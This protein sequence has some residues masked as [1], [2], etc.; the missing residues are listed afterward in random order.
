MPKKEGANASQ[1]LEMKNRKTAN[2][3]IYTPLKLAIEMIKMCDI[4]ENDN[5][6]DC[7]LGKGIFYNNF[8]NCNSDWCE[9]EKG[10]DFFEYTKDKKYDWIIGNPPYSLWNK[11]LDH[12][13]NITDKFCYIFGVFN[14]TPPRVDTILKK[15]FGIT[16][17]TICKVHWWFS[18]SFL[19]VFEKDKK[20]VIDV[21]R[22]SFLC[23]IC[24]NKRCKRG[25]TYKNKKYGIN[26]CSKN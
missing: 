26:E 7:S 25:R 11:W 2:D 17:L 13:C 4:K 10:R 16:R 20:S 8:P 12:T 21:I 18:P 9:I 23:D 15:G 1:F 24:N 6:L 19:V 22:D 5:V 14:L 3:K